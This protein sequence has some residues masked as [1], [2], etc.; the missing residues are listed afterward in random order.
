MMPDDLR[1]S[2]NGVVHNNVVEGGVMRCIQMRHEYQ[3]LEANRG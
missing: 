1:T 2:L 3:F